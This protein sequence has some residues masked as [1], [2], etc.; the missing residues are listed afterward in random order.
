MILKTSFNIFR[1]KLIYDVPA[2]TIFAEGPA[3]V[4]KEV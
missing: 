3:K 4:I 1:D 2:H